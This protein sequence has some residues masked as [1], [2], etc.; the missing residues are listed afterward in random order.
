LLQE[1]HIQQNN[2]VYSVSSRDISKKNLALKRF[3]EYPVPMKCI[4]SHGLMAHSEKRQVTPTFYGNRCQNLPRLLHRA[5]FVKIICSNMPNTC[6]ENFCFQQD[7]PPSHKAIR[8]KKWLEDDLSD[9]SSPSNWPASSP[10]LN[11][12]DYF[13]WE[14]TMAKLD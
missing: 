11:P 6:M 5:C 7:S 10:D 13:A 3:H 12:L 2:R 14:Y 4:Q 1:T 8:T 9:F